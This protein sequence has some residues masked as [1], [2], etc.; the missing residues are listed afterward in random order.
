MSG[1]TENKNTGILYIT[2]IVVVIIFFLWFI[3]TYYGSF[4]SGKPID[5][6][7]ATMID[8]IL[9]NKNNASE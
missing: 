5:T 2:A 9:N 8:Y 7:S 6:A 1:N 3:F 4:T